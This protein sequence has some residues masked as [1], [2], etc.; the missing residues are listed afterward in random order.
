MPEYEFRCMDCKR[1]VSLYLTIAEYG[2]A[3][4]TCPHCGG[5][6]LRRKIGRVRMARSEESRLETLSDPSSWGDV[7]EN[8]PQSMARMMR[9]MS[10]ETGEEMGPEFDDAVDR[11]EAGES[12]DDV[13]SS[14]P[15]LGGD[16][17]SDAEDDF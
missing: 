5:A 8:D 16:G 11:L 14:I 9:R 2:I 15:G 10:Q 12:P 4:P 13:E 7:D 1:V 3:A 6:Q 17:G